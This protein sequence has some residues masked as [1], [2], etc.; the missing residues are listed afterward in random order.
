MLVIRPENIRLGPEAQGDVTLTAKLGDVAFQGENSF[1]ELLLPS[2]RTLL[3]SAHGAAAGLIGAM[4]EGSE[5]RCAWDA[6]DMMA[7]AKA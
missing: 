6:A 7:L 5:I 4:A 1:A 3:A 2:G